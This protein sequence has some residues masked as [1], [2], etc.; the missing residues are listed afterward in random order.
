[1]NSYQ[2]SPS[3]FDFLL[4]LQQNNNRDWFQAHKAQYEAVYEPFKQFAQI[5]FEEVSRHDNL[6]ELKVFRIYRDVRFSK[7]KSPYK[8]YF[9]AGMSR[10]TKWLRGGYYFHI[11]PGQSFAGGGFWAPNAPDLLRIRQEI[12]SD[13]QPLRAIIND[14]VFVQTFGAVE[15]EAVKSAP[16]GFVKDHPAIDLIRK[17]QFLA[18]RAF[19]DQEVTSEYFLAELVQ[20][21]QNL[22]PFFDYMSEVLTTDTN[23]IPLED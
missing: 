5:V 19:S 18:T 11:E 14:P 8:N 3:T 22:R 1:M 10:A 21:L 2:L 7:D 15:G 20:T 17:K 9:S 13:D 16:K 23:G 4:S 6:E 12:A